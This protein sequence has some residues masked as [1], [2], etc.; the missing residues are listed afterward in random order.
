MVNTWGPT[1]AG[2]AAVGTS[3]GLGAGQGPHLPVG[4]WSGTTYRS[5]M[6]W[7]PP[8]WSGWTALTKATLKVKVTDH[9]HVGVRNSS[10][11][12]R[13]QNV[14]DIWTGGSGTQNCNSGFSASNAAQYADMVSSATGQ[15]QFQ[16]GTAENVWKTIDVTAQL[17]YY[18]ANKVPNITLVLAQDTGSDYSEFYSDD[19][20]GNEPTLYLEYTTVTVPDAPTLVAPANKATGV[21]LTPVFQWVHDATDGPQ[22]GAEV[23][24]LETSGPTAKTTIVVTGAAQTAS[25]ALPIDPAIGLN[26]SW[27]VRTQ[28]AQGWSALS[29]YFDFTVPAPASVNIDATRVMIWDPIRKAPGLHVK[30]TANYPFTQY[31]IKTDVPVY[32]SGWVNGAVVDLDLPVA[33]TNGTPINVTVNV[34]D[35]APTPKT[36]TDVQAFTP[37]WGLT[38]QHRDLTTAPNAWQSATI[39]ATKP[40]GSDIKMEYGADATSS[41]APADGWHDDI[42]DCLLV[43]HLFWR[44]WFLPSATASPVLDAVTILS[45]AGAAQTLDKW[46][47]NRAAPDA[48]PPVAQTAMAAPWSVST[49]EYVYGSRSAQCSVTGAGPFYLY[50][51]PILLRAGRT[52]I[53]TGL[54][55][56]QKNSGAQMLLVDDQNAVLASTPALTTDALFYNDKNDVNRYKTDPYVNG[57]ADKTV[58]VA[59]KAGGA[60]GA[61]AYFDAVKV[62]ES[63][64]AT[65]WSPG[66]LGASIVDAG[67]V[68]IDASKGGVFRLRGADDPNV[69]PRA[70]VDL[71][72]KGLRFGGDTELSSP[73]TGIL[74]VNGQPIGG[75]ASVELLR[76]V[77]IAPINIVN[78]VTYTATTAVIHTPSI[79]GIPPEAV[80]VSMQMMGSAS[81]VSPGDRYEVMDYGGNLQAQG[82]SGKVASHWEALSSHYVVLGGDRQFDYRV[83]VGTAG[84]HTIIIMVHGY[85]LKEMSSAIAVGGGGVIGAGGVFPNT[86]AVN[87]RFF[88]TDLKMEFFWNGARWLS[89]TRFLHTSGMYAGSSAALAANTSNYFR[90]TPPSRNGGSDIWVE[91]AGFG[92][93]CLTAITAANYWALALLSYPSGTTQVQLVTQPAPITT[94]TLTEAPV[95]ALLG[96]DVALFNWNIAKAGAPGNLQLHEPWIT[97][98]IVAV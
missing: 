37:R 55:K 38:T 63:T 3:S 43:R 62:E 35:G 52:Y 39:A 98:R 5:I 74:N 36:A 13:R 19:S 53:L 82:F 89:S 75:G 96:S 46:G 27:Q 32:D 1:D 81:V 73:A 16:S 6:R 45:T 18:F 92:W 86:P 65:A 12:V 95:N 4:S 23:H 9:A 90:G 77:P 51:M 25:P 14:S 66:A 50:S 91:T 41:T 94:W 93:Y 15:T 31:Q 97:Y 26:Y 33:L 24:W 10:I 84:N 30:A 49:S 88:R 67:G 2:A 64:V 78:G 87:D 7:A 70:V 48:T 47:M 68:Q 60:A 71:Y 76:Y 20:P 11:L 28:N 8:A 22:L 29:G 80:A 42:S 56:S 21:S 83:T 69:S 58:W 54:M 17:Q 44:A 59:L 85:W 79:T 40:P 61:R 34:R 72:Q 57:G